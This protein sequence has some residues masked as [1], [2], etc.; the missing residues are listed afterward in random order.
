MGRLTQEEFIKKVKE[1]N[2]FFNDGSIELL[3]EYRGRHK[4]V[5]AHCNIHNYDWRVYPETLYEG[6][7]CP[8]CS[9]DILSKNSMNTQEQFLESLYSKNSYFVD[10]ALSLIGKYA[11]M[12]KPVLCHCNIHD[13]DWSPL[14]SSL[15]DGHGCPKCGLESRLNK[16]TMTHDGY[17]QRMQQNN[18][19]II[20]VGKF[21]KTSE[22]IEVKCKNGHTWSA[23]AGN[24]LY[25]HTGCP[26]CRG[27]KVWHGFN[28][29]W[30]TH[31]DIA[32][33]LKNP[34][35]G[36]KYTYGSNV[37]LEFICPD[38]GAIIK[39]RV[40]DVSGYRLVCHRCANGISFPNRFGRAFLDQLPISNCEFEYQPEWAKP[41]F[42]DNYFEYNGS[43]YILEMNGEQ[44]YIEIPMFKNSLKDRRQIDEIKRQLAIE[45]GIN[46]IYINC[47]KSNADY[48]KSN[49]LSSKLKDVFDLSAIDWNLCNKK[50]QRSLVKEVC[51]IYMSGEKDLRII[52][53]KMNLSKSTVF[54]YLKKGA[55]LGWCDYSREKAIE[56]E[57]K[58]KSKPVI[59]L[60]KNNN[61]IHYFNSI[62]E[63]KYQMEKE[64]NV[65]FDKSKISNACKTGVAYRGFNFRFADEQYKINEY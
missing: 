55:K 27:L 12:N 44:H 35:N 37:E 34:E 39:S 11:G 13:Y 56:L 23:N 5:A 63:C 51:S 50:S 2:Q 58:R 30:T 14:A 24:L 49:I 59:T 9:A 36:Y 3:G 17:V 61:I 65:V 53:Q 64:Y 41:Y 22:D 6:R 1:N 20:V 29:L 21:I 25:S 46:I 62:K 8:R 60:G 18:N 19:D 15:Y 57:T 38:C 52:A 43:K 4:R 7:G 16:R 47:F 54:V 40:T 48:I 32:K 33:L 26:Y 42:Y 10:G 45:H 28:D 31:P